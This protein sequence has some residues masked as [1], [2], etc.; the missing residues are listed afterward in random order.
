VALNV[1]IEI[2]VG[3]ASTSLPKMI[4]DDRS[5]AL[6]KTTIGLNVMKDFPAPAYGSEWKAKGDIRNPGQ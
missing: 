6:V 1:V 4:N 3:N 2:D 5:S